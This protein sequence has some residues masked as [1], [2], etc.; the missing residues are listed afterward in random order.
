MN[1]DIWSFKIKHDKKK[2]T[3]RVHLDLDEQPSEKDVVQNMVR[4]IT[5]LK[6]MN[7]RLI[8]LYG[9]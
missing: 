9:V 8:V 5:L 3:V 2:V 4:Y 1:S 7:K 6:N